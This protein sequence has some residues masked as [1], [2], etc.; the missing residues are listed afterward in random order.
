MGWTTRFGFPILES[1]TWRT[2]GVILGIAF[3]FWVE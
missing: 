3:G 1:K 2:E